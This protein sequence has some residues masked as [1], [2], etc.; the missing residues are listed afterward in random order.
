MTQPGREGLTPRASHAVG[1]LRTRGAGYSA[2]APGDSGRDDPFAV[3]MKPVFTGSG[4]PGMLGICSRR[5]GP[6]PVRPPLLKGAAAQEVVVPGPW[7]GDPHLHFNPS[8]TLRLR[9]RQLCFRK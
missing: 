4:L 2:R 8:L 5:S 7:P 3:L 1:E 9:A 6:S